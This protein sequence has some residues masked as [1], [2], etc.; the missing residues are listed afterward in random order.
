[1][2]ARPGYV[3]TA[4]LPLTPRMLDYLRGAA[5]GLT[6]DETAARLGVAVETVKGMRKLTIRRLASR[7]TT[8]AVAIAYERGLLP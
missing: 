3:G 2:S 5:S 8:H 4:E 6:Q 7:N 1:M